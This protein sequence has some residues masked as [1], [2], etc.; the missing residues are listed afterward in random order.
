VKEQGLK[1]AL[2]MAAFIFPFAVAVGAA[3]NWVLR[4]FRIA[5]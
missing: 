2:Y 3:L 1:A 5:L 4:T